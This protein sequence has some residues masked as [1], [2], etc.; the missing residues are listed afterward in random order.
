MY[1]E[2]ILSTRLNE[3]VRSFQ[4]YSNFESVGFL[5]L[6]ERKTRREFVLCMITSLQNIICLYI[7]LFQ[8]DQKVCF[9]H[10]D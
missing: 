1:L 9:W 8:Y 6:Y 4:I 3:Y 7:W 5:R 10:I 2:V